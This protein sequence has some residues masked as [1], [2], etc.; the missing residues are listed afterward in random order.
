MSIIG[1]GFLKGYLK[2]CNLLMAWVQHWSVT[3]KMYIFIFHLYL[4]VSKYLCLYCLI[5]ILHYSQ[6]LE[7]A[8]KKLVSYAKYRNCVRH[9]YA[10]WKKVHKRQEVKKIFQK[11]VNSTYEV[12]FHRN[13]GI[14]NDL[15]EVA[16]GD[17]LHQDPKVFCKAIV[18]TLLKCDVII[19]NLAETFN[20]YI[21]K[22]KTLPIIAMLED[23]MRRLDFAVVEASQK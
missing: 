9:I 23:I 13:M 17:L 8:I 12:E 14:L 3:N 6:G 22:A 7:K 20:F 18:S 1:D 15:F 2:T 21:C 10:N 11:I 16:Y 4:N 19:S 5:L